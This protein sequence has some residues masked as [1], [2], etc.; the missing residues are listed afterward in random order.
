MMT[1][2]NKIDIEDFHLWVKGIKSQIKATQIKAAI[3][4]NSE[5]LHLYWSLGEQIVEKEKSSKWGDKLLH[6]LSAELLAEFPSMKGFSR[7]NLYCI[8]QWYLFYNQD[9][10]IV[11]QV[12][13]QFGEEFF[14]IPWGHHLYILY[15]TKPSD[16]QTIGLLV[17][18]TKNDVLA[19]WTLENISQPIGVSSYELAQ[20]L[21]DEIKS[22]LPSIEE[23]EANIAAELD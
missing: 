16:A 19:R 7:R 22:S 20:A 8:K 5:L 15:H 1:K 4:V 14:S 18:K 21:P 9:D 11:Q 12:V 17:C 23:I 3:K 13:A 6:N 2:Q 10:I